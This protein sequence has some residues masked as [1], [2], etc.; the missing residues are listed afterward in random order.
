MD[1][2]QEK[3]ERVIGDDFIEWLNSR[4]K[5]AYRFKTRPDRAPD[6]I[7][8]SANNELFIEVTAA[9]YDEK[10]A[11]FI[12][13]GVRGKADAP[14]N[15]NGIN[16]NASL[17]NEIHNCIIK[18]AQKRYG[19]DTLLLIE[20]PPGVTSAEELSELLELQQF[21]KDSP[22]AG[23]YIVGNFPIKNGSIGG[24]RVIPIHEL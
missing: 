10:H 7:Y 4:K 11:R 3:N 5:T 2:F 17:I 24:F 1:K 9:F 23:I 15:W 6:L 13:K 22:F 20:V 8:T 16:A 18:K 12:W 21:P 19:K 14:A